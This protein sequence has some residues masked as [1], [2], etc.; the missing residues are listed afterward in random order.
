MPDIES[1]SLARTCFHPHPKRQVPWWCPPAIIQFP[2]IQ[3]ELGFDLNKVPSVTFSSS[4]RL[5]LTWS[6]FSSASQKSLSLYCSSISVAC[7]CSFFLSFFLFYITTFLSFF[8][9]RPSNLPCLYPLA[10]CPYSQ[11]TARQDAKP[12]PT[13][14]QEGQ[15]R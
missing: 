5:S 7:C 14:E 10:I 12:L 11:T 15:G 13:S 6:P 4:S 9:V 2:R 1:H 3:L 8:F